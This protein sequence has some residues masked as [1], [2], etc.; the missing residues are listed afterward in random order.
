MGVWDGIKVLDLSWGVAGPS[1]A[2]LLCDHGADVIRIERPEGDPFDGMLD[3]RVYRRG[4]RSAVI[5]LRSDDDKGRFLALAAAADVVI[6]S[7]APGVT[8]RL[9]IDYGTLAASNP[10]LV[11]CSI[12]GYGRTSRHAAR[13]AFDQLVAAR[14][15]YQWEVRC[16][17]GSAADLAAGRDPLLGDTGIAAAE[18]HW[19]ERPGPVFM[20]TPSG[21]VAAGYLAALGISGALRARGVTGRGQWVE[22]S[23]LQGMFAYQG[24]GWLRFERG[25]GAGRPVLM[26]PI[27]NHG[28]GV[29][30]MSGPWSFYQCGDGRWV[31]QW[32]ARP[33]WAILAGEGDQLRPVD[34]AE[35]DALMAETGG[36]AGSL[37]QQLR[38]RLRAIPVFAKFTQAE[39]VRHSAA[40]GFCMQP[41]RSPEEVRC[42][43]ALLAEGSVVELDDPEL[44]PLRQAGL[45]YRLHRTPGRVSGPAPIRGADT[46]AVRAEADAGKGRQAAAPATPVEMAG[47]L[48]GVKVLDFGLAMAGPWGGEMLAHLGAD[49]VKIDPVRQNVWLS[50][51]MSMAVNRS[52]RHLQ[53]DVKVPEGLAAAYE[54]VRQADI[55]LMNIRGQAAQ[56]LHLDYESLQAVNPA[57]IYCHTA[58]FDDSRATLPGNDQTGNAVGGTEW[59]DG[60]CANGGRPYWSFGTGGDL[61]NGFLSAVAMVQALY[62]R[63]RTGEGQKVDTSILNAALFATARCYTTPDGTRFDRPT[64][65]PELLGL[66]ALYRLYQCA[67]GWLCLAAF[68]AE[69]WKALTAVMPALR[70]DDRFATAEARRAN[71]GALQRVLEERF[72]TDAAVGWFKLL[73]E[74]GV[75]CE[76]SSIEFIEGLYDDQELIDRE[77]IVTRDGHPVHGRMEMFGRLV[78]FSDTTPPV[79]G[80]PAVPG[81]HSR[82]V[83]REYGFA[84]AD[85]DRLRELHAV[86]EFD[87][88]G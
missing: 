39:W 12:T 31:N 32:T 64:P 38:T 14:T 57:L 4:Q 87:G 35:L 81:Q 77:L 23:L 66:S 71:D 68:G 47:P 76:V 70:D 72:S 33:E 34:Q 50:S 44:G 20:T 53:L 80:P 18:R 28:P 88:G 17:P 60:G 13:P 36:R 63:D 7:F 83:L 79:G 62:H 58:G 45:L 8:D 5:D 30:L 86:Y 37:E 21:S 16:W 75:P 55:V 51:N 73:D 56:K 54:L 26:G 25:G 24:Y 42:D 67:E 6:E 10:G 69:S 22:T 85:I 3:D 82:E 1:A 59:E 11:Y 29:S 2:M 19:F 27:M 74:A 46:A 15:G 9:G 40:A 43:P 78:E 49:V 52:K 41:V 65:D 84:D 61:G 48:A